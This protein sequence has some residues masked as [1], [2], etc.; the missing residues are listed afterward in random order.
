MRMKRATENYV[1]FLLAGVEKII[2][3]VRAV[4]HTR[5]PAR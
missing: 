3:G 2:A 1:L 5:P 4:S